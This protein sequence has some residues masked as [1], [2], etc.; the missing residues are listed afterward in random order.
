MIDQKKIAI[1]PIDPE[2]ASP[3]ITRKHYARRLPN[4]MFSFGMFADSDLVGIVT[5][6][7]PASPNLTVGIAGE[8]NKHLVLELNRLFVEDGIPRS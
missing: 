5:Y 4:I 6:G 3:W 2:L 8:E 1:R 7:S